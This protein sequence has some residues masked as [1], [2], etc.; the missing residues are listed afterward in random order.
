MIFTEEENKTLKKLKK[1]IYYTGQRYKVGVPWREDKHPLP[2]YRHT[3]SIISVVK[4]RK[5]TEEGLFFSL[6]LEKSTPKLSEGM[7]RKCTYVNLN[8]RSHYHR[9]FGICPTSQ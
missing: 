4:Y 8:Q 5:Q 7:S 1:S 9:K 3:C 2:D 6:L